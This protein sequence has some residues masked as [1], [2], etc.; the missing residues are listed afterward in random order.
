MTIRV[1]GTSFQVDFVHGGKRYR[2][3]KPTMQEAKDCEITAKANL[4]KGLD[5]FPD[6]ATKVEEKKGKTFGESSEEVWNLE[7]SKGKSATKTRNRLNLVQMDIGRD[8]LLTDITTDRLDQY[9]IELER[10]GNGGGTINRKISVISKVLKHAYRREELERMPFIPRQGEPPTRFRWYT[11]DEQRTILEACRENKHE[12]F[13]ILMAVLFDTGMRISEALDLTLDN[14]DFDKNLIT[15]HYGETKNNDARSIPMTKRVVRLLSRVQTN[16][17]YFTMNYNQANEE[18]VQ[19]RSRIGMGKGDGIH[20]IRHTFCSRLSQ[21]GTDMRVIQELAGH[22]DLSTT[23]RY[24][25]LNPETL[26]THIDK[27][28]ACADKDDL[29]V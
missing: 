24:T 27:L 23:Q 16:D 6:E 13:F 9:T 18:W 2:K 1:R 5:P 29:I 22:K 11:E 17:R 19:V 15:L 26:K 28:E 10:I 4:I 7:W 25:H 8:T 12:E 14:T 20:S 3:D 21:N